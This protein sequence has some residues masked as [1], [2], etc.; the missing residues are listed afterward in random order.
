MGE[1][2][3]GQSRKR[4]SRPAGGQHAL[5]LTSTRRAN[6][7]SSVCA[8]GGAARAIFFTETRQKQ[9][10]WPR[11]WENYGA[12]WRNYPFIPCYCVISR[13]LYIP[14]RWNESYQVSTDIVWLTGTVPVLR[15]YI[16]HTSKL[17]LNIYQLVYGRFSSI[18]SS[19]PITVTFG[20][21]VP[22]RVLL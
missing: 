13:R 15:N 8:N 7:K 17:M 10:A 3:V 11:C 21:N 12:L 16:F 19:S 6:A 2:G 22:L 4:G 14:N 20:S 5:V 1:S 9:T 18:E